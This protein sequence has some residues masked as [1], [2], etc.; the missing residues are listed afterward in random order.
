MIQC[1]TKGSL[2]ML[3]I[4]MQHT[5][6]HIPFLVTHI[7]PRCNIRFV[8]AIRSLLQKNLY[9]LFLIII[10]LITSTRTISKLRQPILQESRSCQMIYTSLAT[11]SYIKKFY[12]ISIRNVPHT[13]HHIFSDYYIKLYPYAR[14]TVHNNKIMNITSLW[15]LSVVKNMFLH[16]RGQKK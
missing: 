2:S 14:I 1:N 15:I 8:I 9:I 6:I 13:V 5:L 3:V 4:G 16:T 7:T 10:Y 12:H 11:H